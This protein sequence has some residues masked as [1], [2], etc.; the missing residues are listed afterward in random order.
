MFG[1]PALSVLIARLED[2]EAFGDFLSLIREYLP[3]CEREILHEPTPNRQMAVFAS[4][5][6]DRYFPLDSNFM[7]GWEE[8]YSGLTRQIPIIP[9]GL[10]YDDFVELSS[11]GRPGIQLMTYLLEAGD[12]DDRVALAE[13]CEEHVPRETLQRAPEGGFSFKTIH[14]LVDKTKFN[15]LALWADEIT[16]DTGNLFLDTDDETLYSGYVE[17][18]DWTKENVEE[19]TTEW[20]K[21]DR[22]DEQIANLCEWLEGDPPARFEE[23]LNFMLESKEKETAKTEAIAPGR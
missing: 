20:Q 8:E 5:F 9:R 17:R 14:K 13:A 2:S 12:N 18:V 11:N 4:H 10:S 1:P 16:Q 23:L 19:L 3:E 7:D 15:A 21:A 6:E 22:I